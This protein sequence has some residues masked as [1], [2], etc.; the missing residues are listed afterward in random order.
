VCI[1]HE[2]KRKDEILRNSSAIV[3]A[4]HYLWYEFPIEIVQGQHFLEFSDNK[5]F[6]FTARYARDAE[7]AEKDSFSI[8]F[9]KE[10]NG[11]LKTL[12]ALR[13]CGEYFY[14]R[15]F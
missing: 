14:Q 12:R 4:Y 11:K 2:P 3:E 13:L 9:E 8:A 10:G 15:S 1:R 5:W 6:I 7:A